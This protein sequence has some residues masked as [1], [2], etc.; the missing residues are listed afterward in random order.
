MPAKKFPAFNETG[1]FVTVHVADFWVT[2]LWPNVSEELRPCETL[3]FHNT[4]G[5]DMN[6][7]LET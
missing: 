1:R 7:R 4:D 2:K 3:K 5:H 6:L